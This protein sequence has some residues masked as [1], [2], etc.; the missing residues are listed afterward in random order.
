M[1]RAVMTYLYY[2]FAGFIEFIH[3]IFGECYY[4]YFSYSYRDVKLKWR[5]EWLLPVSPEIISCR[6]V[7][8]GRYYCGLLV[9]CG[10]ALGYP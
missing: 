9:V 6:K 3:I 7:W 8:D 1:L 5:A 2:L 4:S 10:L